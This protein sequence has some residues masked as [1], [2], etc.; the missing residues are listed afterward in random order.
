MESLDLS[1]DR[2]SRGYGE[3]KTMEAAL[4]RALHSLD[5]AT[6]FNINP[7]NVTSSSSGLIVPDIESSSSQFNAMFDHETDFWL[8]RKHNEITTGFRSTEIDDGDAVEV[9]ADSPIEALERLAR[10]YHFRHHSP[11]RIR[12][13]PVTLFDGNNA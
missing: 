8:A 12:G 13:L 1:V 5:E 2:P 7:A 3:G 10:R 4:V 9:T 11:A 6:R